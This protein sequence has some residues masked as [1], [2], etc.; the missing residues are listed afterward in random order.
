M[1]I[2][3]NYNPGIGAGVLLVKMRLFGVSLQW[4][5]P[6]A[7]EVS[8]SELGNVDF[9]AQAFY[10]GEARDQNV[11]V[12]FVGLTSEGLYFSGDAPTAAGRYLETAF[13]LGGNYLAIPIVRVVTI[14][15][16]A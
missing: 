15:A 10:E 2:N 9:G 11:R 14:N 3:R 6:D 7:K 4:N 16:A 1:A 13:P 5:S 12:L 8:V